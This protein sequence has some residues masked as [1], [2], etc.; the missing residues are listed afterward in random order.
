VAASVRLSWIWAALL[1]NMLSVRRLR[2]GS[3]ILP[4][5]SKHKLASLLLTQYPSAK[6]S[7]ELLL[8]F[9]PGDAL[10]DETIV[11]TAIEHCV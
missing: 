2:R 4:Q 3:V 9:K 5:R 10:R 6:S 1:P 8:R 7:V 11:S